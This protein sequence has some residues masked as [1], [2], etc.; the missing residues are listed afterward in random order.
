MGL[1]EGRVAIVTGAAQ[2]LGQSLAQAL[3]SE[4][5]WV[6]AAG[7]NLSKC[8][9]TADEIVARGGVAIAAQCDVRESGQ[10]DRCV[11][12]AAASFGRIDILV[13]NA[14]QTGPG[15]LLEIDEAKIA[16]Q[17]ESG[18]LATL[19]FM[20]ACHPY[21][22]ARDGS[23]GGVIINL[24]SQAGLV[25]NP[26]GYG[27]YGAVKEAIRT[28]SRTAACEWGPDGIRVYTLVPMANTPAM[29]RSQQRQSPE[30]RET[31]LGAIPLRRIGDP[32]QD[33]GPVAVFLCS[34]GARYLTGISVSADGG[35][36]HIG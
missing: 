27:V 21:L 26:S 14:G 6:V 4:G 15:R 7:R 23:A 36:S 19:R 9:H 22:R 16:A 34:D 1:L 32:I 11:A 17:W 5:A 30:Q 29:Q 31:M 35:Y 8:R 18:P 25:P 33:I 28:L 13:N 20:R 3:A 10:I 24:G 2:G 12:T